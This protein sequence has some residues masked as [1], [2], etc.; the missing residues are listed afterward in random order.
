MT[1]FYW[2]Y[3]LLTLAA[4]ILLHAGA[5]TANDYF[6]HKSG[7]DEANLNFFTP[8]YGGSRVIQNG[9]MRPGEMLALSLSCLGMGSAIGVYLA[10][11]RGLP[12]LWLGLIGILSGFF[13]TAPP[14]SLANRGLGEL[15]ILLNFGILPTLGAYYVQARSF[16][17]EVFLASIPVGLLMANVLII[18]EFPDYQADKQAGKRH[19]VV[20]MG[21]RKARWLYLLILI[22]TFLCI[23][24]FASFR[25][26]SRFALLSLLT[27]PLA[28]KIGMN[29]WKYY[30]DSRKLLPSNIGSIAAH[31]S[32]GALLCLG[33]ILQK[34]L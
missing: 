8:I 25:L 11:S 13:Y 6:D 1:T 17:L 2:G 28:I 29:T 31:S 20:R 7:A 27:L 10:V 18:N 12:I 19:L 16:S 34:L 32:I 4:A 5:N 26:I 3:F 23:I 21:K 9:E 24:L 14:I 22:F 33:Y 30:A 15:A